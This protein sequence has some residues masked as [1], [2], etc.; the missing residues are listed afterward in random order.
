MPADGAP[1]PPVSEW[2]KVLSLPPW[3]PDKAFGFLL[4]FERERK[5]DR[6]EEEV[7]CGTLINIRYESNRHTRSVMEVSD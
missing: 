1:A 7:Q 6:E 4:D 2:K 3:E 5:E